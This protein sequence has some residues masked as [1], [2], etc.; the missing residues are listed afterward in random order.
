MAFEDESIHREKGA[1]I[2]NTRRLMFFITGI[3]VIHKQKTVLVSAVY[4]YRACDHAFV[5]ILVSCI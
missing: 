2:N 1:A 4:T 5:Y 3:S